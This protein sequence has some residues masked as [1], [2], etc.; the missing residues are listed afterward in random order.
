MAKTLTIVL[1][2]GSQEN[3]DPQL[4]VRLAEA[5]QARGHRV[6][7]FLY[8]NGCNLAKPDVPAVGPLGIRA[9]LQAHLDQHK[10]GPRLTALAAGGAKIVTCHTTEYARGI[11][12][13]P[14]LPGVRRGDVGHVFT[15]L[16]LTSDV[17]LCLGR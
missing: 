11:E 15:E 3:E 10:L 4:A 12:G 9:S 14:Y 13:Q 16:L 8:G 6:N 2:A 1:T 5:A 17:L 7:I